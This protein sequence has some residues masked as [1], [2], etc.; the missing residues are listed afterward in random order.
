M[1]SVLTALLLSSS[2]LVSVVRAQADAAH[3][4][5]AAHAE[6][7]VQAY[8]AGEWERAL[9]G[10]HRAHALLPGARTLRGIAMCEVQLGRWAEAYRSLEAALAM[11]DD[12]ERALTPELREHVTEL[13]AEARS[14]VGVWR[15]PE[16]VALTIEGTPAVIAADRTL[17]IAEGTY[18]LHVR[19]EDGREVRVRVEIR[20]GDTGPLIWVLPEPE[21]L[22]PPDERP[23]LGPPRVAGGVEVRED[24]GLGTHVPRPV[25]TRFVAWAHGVA[26]GWI[27]GFD[28]LSPAAGF[29][30]G[31][32][33][34][35]RFFDELSVGSTFDGTWTGLTEACEPAAAR[36]SDTCGWFQLAWRLA[37][38]IRFDDVPLSIAVAPG[39]VLGLRNGYTSRGPELFADP[40]FALDVGIRWLFADDWLFLGL[41]VRGAIGPWANLGTA[42]VLGFQTP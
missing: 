8:E 13:L 31:A 17:V 1:R 16:G 39:F 2:L 30:F 22:E 37:L 7:A 38:D 6:L 42:L 41:D 25:T 11:P 40:G 5:Y 28:F 23:L 29:G 20:G 10:F 33:A 4:L 12:G 32:G 14:H 34:L 15:M 21:P 36:R 35:T 9:E 19:T 24:P 27:G 18:A 3:L 26:G